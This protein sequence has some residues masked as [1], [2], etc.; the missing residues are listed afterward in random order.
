[1]NVVRPL[2]VFIC[3]PKKAIG[4]GTGTHAPKTSEND[5]FTR[6]S[7]NIGYTFEIFETI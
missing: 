7:A 3:D 1:M 4:I 6:K 2:Y 5:W